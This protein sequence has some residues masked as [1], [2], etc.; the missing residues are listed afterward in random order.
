MAKN[1]PS[2]FDLDTAWKDA[3][4]LFKDNFGLMAVIAGVFVFLPSAIVILALPEMAQLGQMG[5][6]EASQE[7]MQAA[8]MA[9]YSEH[10][11]TLLL[12]LVVQTIGI[13]ALLALLR[14]HARPTVGEAIGAGFTSVP[15][16]LAV[17]IIFFVVIF[18]LAMVLIGITAAIGG[19]PLATVGSIVFAVIAFYLLIKFLLA[20]VVIAMDDV[21]NPIAAMKASWQLTKGNSLRLFFFMAMIIIVYL[22]VAYL[23]NSVFS[24]I[25]ALGGPEVQ[26]FGN[27]IVS[28][29]ISA[30]FT[31][32]LVSILAAIY[33]Q[34]NRLK[35]VG[36][37]NA[38][39]VDRP[40]DY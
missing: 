8:V 33:V 17:Q 14:R 16:Y 32:L 2:K 9:F 34:I 5:G 36:A 22:I 7:A 13:L 19:V 15:S 31:M 29:T 4:R 6:G 12:Q 28:S 40:T 1:H 21:R 39:P 11:L 35:G 10:W 18:V 26:L 20:P 27:A 37:R 24:L 38:A 23:V 3:T 25:F 30:L